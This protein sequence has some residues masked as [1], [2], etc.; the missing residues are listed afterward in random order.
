MPT[1]LLQAGWRVFFYSNEGD[2]PIHVHFRKGEIEC[3]F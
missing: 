2:E 1:I 3:K